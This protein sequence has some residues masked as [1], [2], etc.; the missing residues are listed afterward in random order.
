MSSVPVGSDSHITEGQAIPARWRSLTHNHISR[1][2]PHSASLV[3]QL[4]NETGSFSSAQQSL[5][6]VR[7]VALEEIESIV[8][9]SLRLEFAF[10]VEVMSSDMTLTIGAPGTVFD[11]VRMTDELESDGAPT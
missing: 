6:F 3:E 2:P 10:R 11:G 1:P 4:A 9:F 8:R 5:E 7:G